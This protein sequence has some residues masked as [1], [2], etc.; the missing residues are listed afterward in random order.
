MM[1]IYPRKESQGASDLRTYVDGDT[2]WEKGLLYLTEQSW[3]SPSLELEQ[4]AMH[5]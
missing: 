2:G 3:S 1:D 4:E 5:L